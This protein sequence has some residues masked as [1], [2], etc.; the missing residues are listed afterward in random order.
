M[1]TV[2]AS[3]LAQPDAPTLIAAQKVAD[4]QPRI[5]QIAC[6]VCGGSLRADSRFCT[7]C[8]AALAV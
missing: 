8:G 1:T 3:H 2:P 6:G 4:A 7:E 5:T